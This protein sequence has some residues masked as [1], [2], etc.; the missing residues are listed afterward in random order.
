MSRLA[1]EFCIPLTESTSRAELLQRLAGSDFRDAR[2][3][4]SQQATP[5]AIED[6]PLISVRG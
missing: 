6:F 2:L 4:D 1:A 5:R 3:A